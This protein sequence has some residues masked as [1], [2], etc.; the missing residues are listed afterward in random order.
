MLFSEN[1]YDDDD[2]DDAPVVKLGLILT[3]TLILP[4]AWVWDGVLAHATAAE[5]TTIWQKQP[6]LP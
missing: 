5:R 4:G 3:I 6:L 1:K 2:D